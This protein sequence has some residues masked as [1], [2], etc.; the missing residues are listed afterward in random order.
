LTDHFICV[1]I[2]YFLQAYRAMQ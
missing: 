2:I 1:K